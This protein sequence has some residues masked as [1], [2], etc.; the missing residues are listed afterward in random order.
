[1]DRLLWA[2]AWQQKASKSND[3][4]AVRMVMAIQRKYLRQREKDCF[5]ILM[6]I[7]LFELRK[8]AQEYRA[9]VP[10]FGSRDA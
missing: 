2:K 7:N 6:V 3:K 9:I 1:M 5:F 8:W 10:A 4:M